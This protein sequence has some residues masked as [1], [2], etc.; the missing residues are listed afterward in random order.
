MYAKHDNL[1]DADAS[2]AKAST[3]TLNHV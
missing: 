2:S 3:K 1:V